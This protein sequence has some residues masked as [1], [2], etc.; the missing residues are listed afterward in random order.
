MRFYNHPHAY[1]C[2]VD[3]H[4]RSMFKRVLDHA[5]AASASCS[6]NDPSSKAT[7]LRTTVA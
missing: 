3:L 5:G 2:G 7:E 6:R 4:A 1:Y